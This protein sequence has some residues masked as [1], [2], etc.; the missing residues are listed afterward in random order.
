MIAV[1]LHTGHKYPTTCCRCPVLQL[2]RG[3]DIS[4]LVAAGQ[5]L[6]PAAG[7]R[8][9]GEG[10]HFSSYTILRCKKTF[11]IQ[12]N[13]KTECSNIYRWIQYSLM[14]N[15]Y[16]EYFVHILNFRKSSTSNENTALR[17]ISFVFSF[18]PELKKNAFLN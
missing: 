8:A 3:R 11:Y 6:W 10:A 9:R 15:I 16:D 4:T 5:D 7:G 2:A 18:S 14:E 13:F 17:H 12:Q 1:H